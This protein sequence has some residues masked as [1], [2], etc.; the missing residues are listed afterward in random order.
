MSSAGNPEQTLARRPVRRISCL[1]GLLL[2]LIAALALG[3]QVFSIFY[4]ILFPPMPFIPSTSR[5]ISH[6]SAGPGVDTW[7]FALDQDV[8]ST[9]EEY[10]AQGADCRLPPDCLNSIEVVPSSAVECRGTMDFSIFSMRWTATI[11]PD[12]LSEHILLRLEREILWFGP[13]ASAPLPF[14]E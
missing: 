3:W 2:V 9:L 12:P 10:L 4:A 11:S 8:C 5:E 7:L 13:S 14:P 6:E 1:A